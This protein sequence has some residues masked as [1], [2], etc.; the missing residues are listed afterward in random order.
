MLRTTIRAVQ[1]LWNE[2]NAPMRISFMTFACPDY[3][4]DQVMALGV[5]HGYGG[6][7]FRCDSDHRH[8]VMIEST[9]AQRAELRHK[10]VDAGLEAPCLATSLQFIH[11]KAVEQA[12][13]RIELAVDIGCPALRVFCGPLPDGVGVDSAIPM[14][15]ANLRRAAGR[16]LKAGVKLWLETH[17]SI[18]LGVHAGRIVRLVDHPAV[19]INWDNMHPFRVGEPLAKTWEAIGPFIQHTHFH[20][21]VARPGT[22]VIRPFG[23]GELPLQ[24]MYNLLRFSGYAGY[25]SGEWFGDQMGPDPDA[26]LAIY[27]QGLQALEQRWQ[28]MQ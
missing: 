26:S 24:Q 19:A 10:L 18:S 11:Q 17:D 20:D 3:A 2:G 14:V 27:K 22:P 4:F 25:F 12:L 5:R 7:E 13:P 8:G 16:A 15:A 1:C 21:A 9:K 6:V 28:A 23:Q